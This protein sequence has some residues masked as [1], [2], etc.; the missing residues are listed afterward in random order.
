MKPSYVL[1]FII[2]FAL[3][4]STSNCGKPMPTNGKDGAQGPQGAQGQSGAAGTSLFSKVATV[5]PCGPSS[6]PYKEVLL[7]L[8]DC[9]L[10]SS[11]SVDSNALNTRFTLVPDGTYSDTD[12]SGCVFTVSS[13]PTTRTVSWNAGTN[14]YAAWAAGTVTC[15]LP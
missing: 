4:L 8:A 3:S 6:S 7:F 5:T 15:V 10:L 2:G 1:F 13:A 11:F 12:S 14:A 9:S